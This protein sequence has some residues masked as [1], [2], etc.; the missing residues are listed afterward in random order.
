MINR[1][2]AAYAFSCPFHILPKLKKN[3]CLNLYHRDANFKFNY[4]KTKEEI[5]IAT[6]GYILDWVQKA[7][8]PIFNMYTKD[9]YEYLLKV[10]K[11]NHFA[12]YMVIYTPLSFEKVIS[13]LKIN[14]NNYYICW[15]V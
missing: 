3:I 6:Q 14:I 12:C 1:S 10:L 8:I 4:Y 15:E 13:R 5:D 7:T 11:Q 2:A 9:H